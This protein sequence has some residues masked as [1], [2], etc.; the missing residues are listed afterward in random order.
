[1]SN[2][3]NDT[4]PYPAPPP[5]G[6]ESLHAGADEDDGAWLQPVTYDQTDYQA[7]D[8]YLALDADA[9]GPQAPDGASLGEPAF[10]AGG[11]Y[12]DVLAGNRWHT[13]RGRKARV[14]RRRH[15]AEARRKMA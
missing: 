4:A 15:R 2:W 1:V 3:D 5:Y 9:G 10:P 14:K 8:A 11:G 13:L 6:Q 7:M 12:A